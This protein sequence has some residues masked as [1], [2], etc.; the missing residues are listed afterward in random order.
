LDIL[1]LLASWAQIIT[2]PLTIIG[3]AVAAW[4]TIWVYRRGQQKRAITCTIEDV[5]SPIAIEAGEALG[6]V[7]EIRYKGEPVENL[8][9]VRANLKNSG[10][11][12]IRK[13]DVVEPI[14]FTFAEDAEL[15]RQPVV[16]NRIPK[17]LKIDWQI[18]MVG[19]PPGV[20]SASLLL[21]L[22]N[23][24]EEM[25]VEFVCTGRIQMPKVEARIEG[26][27]K[28]DVIGPYEAYLLKKTGRSPSANIVIAICALLGIALTSVPASFI[29]LQLG[30]GFD[31]ILDWLITAM[32][33]ALIWA[34]VLSPAVELRRLR[35]RRQIIQGL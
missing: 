1:T 16:L 23:P 12:A 15:I 3:I 2:L 9:V 7:I 19:N 6:G 11:V 30:K 8:F 18:P 4:L 31:F 27:S 5:L 10:N 29:D 33:V 17:E 25:T 13:S 34:T 14:R 28:I 32:A 21:D 26:I 24:R 20:N 35:R 22:L